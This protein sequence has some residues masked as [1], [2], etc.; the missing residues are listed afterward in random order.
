MLIGRS[1]LHARERKSAGSLPLL[2][3]DAVY[4]GVA[5]LVRVNPGNRSGS[6]H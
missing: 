4:E 6:Y 5:K 1:V 2:G 3:V